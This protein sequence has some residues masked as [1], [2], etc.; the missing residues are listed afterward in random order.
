MDLRQLTALG[1]TLWQTKAGCILV[2]TEIAPG[3]SDI[4]A[5]GI[6]TPSR[7]RGVDGRGQAQGG[8]QRG[9]EVFH[10]NACLSLQLLILSL[11]TE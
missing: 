1:H 6:L 10:G 9:L 7:G 5:G 4:K 11:P 3:S 8:G 2:R